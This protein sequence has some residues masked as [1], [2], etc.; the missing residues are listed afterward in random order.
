MFSE[1]FG[2]I[3]KSLKYLNI[4]EAPNDVILKKPSHSK[5]H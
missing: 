3:M 1:D 5:T 4:N 2:V